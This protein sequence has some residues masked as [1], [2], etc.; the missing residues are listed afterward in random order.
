MNQSEQRRRRQ[1]PLAPSRTRSPTRRR[2]R[3]P[4]QSLTLG[5]PS[6]GTTEANLALA[7]GFGAEETRV[8]SPRAFAVALRGGA[9]I[10]WR[11]PGHSHK[12]RS[13]Q[14][15]T[16]HTTASLPHCAP[17]RVDLP[18]EAGVRAELAQLHISTIYIASAFGKGR[19]AATATAACHAEVPLPHRSLPLPQLP[20]SHAR[21]EATA[22]RAG[23][24][25][26]ISPWP[27]RGETACRPNSLSKRSWTWMESWITY[28]SSVYVDCLWPCAF[29]TAEVVPDLLNYLSESESTS[30]LFLPYCSSQ[31]H[32]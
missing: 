4:V 18:T 2:S 32:N 26:P 22:T 19:A 17:E 10:S 28:V 20:Y 23:Q 6:G 5:V 24:P 15:H 16:L 29:R 11:T 7:T 21:A 13:S 27:K 1:R 25:A 3:S 14:P 12:R 30:S 9:S 31:N 8:R